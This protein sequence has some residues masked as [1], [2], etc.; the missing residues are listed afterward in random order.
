MPASFRHP[1]G[2][3]SYS[4]GNVYEVRI[5][6]FAPGEFPKVLTR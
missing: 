3:Q 6:I 4:T 2:S 1:L 5:Y